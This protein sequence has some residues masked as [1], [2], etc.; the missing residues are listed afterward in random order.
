MIFFIDNEFNGMGG[1]LISM[2][3][4]S[5]CGRH[6]FYEVVECNEPLE[7][8]V[9]EHVRPFLNKTAIAT[10]TFQKRLYDFLAPF[11]HSLHIVADFPDDIKYFTEATLL[12]PGESFGF[13]IMNL[14]VD[15]RLSARESTIPHN[16]LED[17]RAIRQSWKKLTYR[18]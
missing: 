17:A 5:E 16:A 1:A 3:L 9:R 4:V 6:E 2:A 14:Q 8:W 13:E 18:R 11:Q 15:N 12:G 7:D 10:S